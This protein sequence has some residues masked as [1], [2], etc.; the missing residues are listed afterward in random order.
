MLCAVQNI[1]TPPPYALQTKDETGTSEI[2][3]IARWVQRTL[4]VLHLTLHDTIDIA[5]QRLVAS[6]KRFPRQRLFEFVLRN[7]PRLQETEAWTISV[8]PPASCRSASPQPP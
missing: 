7:A 8:R 4:A 1:P 3:R 2:L 5:T 6:L